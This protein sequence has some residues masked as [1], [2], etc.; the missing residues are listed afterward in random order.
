MS[1]RQIFVIWTHPLFRESLALLLNHPQIE[2]VGETCDY[3]TA[4]QDVEKL[5]PNTIL[6]EETEGNKS[7]GFINELNKQPWEMRILFLNLMDNQLNFFHHERRTLGR[8]EDLVQMILSE[9]R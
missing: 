3:E 8:T 1:T 5:R 6:I 2:L 4:L 9:M 7:E